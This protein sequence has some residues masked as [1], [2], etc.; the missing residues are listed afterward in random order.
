M[1]WNNNA[2][3]IQNLPIIYQ[4][5]LP[6]NSTANSFL[7]SKIER[8]LLIDKKGIIQNGYTNLYAYDIEEQL[9]M[10]EKK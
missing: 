3:Y 8:L 1:H 10:L 5:K 9:T 6:Q 2:N 7:T 4:Y